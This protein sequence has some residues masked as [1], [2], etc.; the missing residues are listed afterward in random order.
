[1]KTTQKQKKTRK[2]LKPIYM[3]KVMRL[4]GSSREKPEPITKRTKTHPVIINTSI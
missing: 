2:R 3:F 1:M 4:M